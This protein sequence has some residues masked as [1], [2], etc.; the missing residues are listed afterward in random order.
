MAAVEIIVKAA[1]PVQQFNRITAATDRLK[2]GVK[3]AQEAL[4]AAGKQGRRAGTAIKSGLDKAAR[5]ADKF[6]DKRNCD[7]SCCQK[8]LVSLIAYSS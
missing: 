2:K 5:S 8:N 4:D 7:L 1:Q 3:R 6:A